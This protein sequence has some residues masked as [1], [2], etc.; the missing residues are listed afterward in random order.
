MKIAIVIHRYGLDIN[1]GSELHCRWIAE[2]LAKT[3]QVDILTTCAKDYITWRNELPEG[4]QELNS[5][6]IHRF[7]VERERNIYEFALQSKRVFRNPKMN[8]EKAELAWLKSEGPYAPKLI[9]YITR[10]QHNYD[11]FIFYCYRY[12]LSY[13]GILTVPK[14]SILIPTAEHD[15]TI[16]LK[17]S[18]TLLNKPKAIIYLTPEEKQLIE[19]ITHN[20]SI[21]N[22]ILGVGITPP[23]TLQIEDFKKKYQLNDDFLL[24]VGRIDPNKGCDQLFQYYLHYLKTHRESRQIP[25]LVLLGKNVMKIPKHQQIVYLGTL[26]EQDKW[27][28]LATAKLFIMPSK[29]ESLCIA[30]LEAMSVGK[31]VLV[32]GTC[33]VLKGHCRRSNG[34]LYYQSYEEFVATLDYLL[35]HD[36][37]RRQLGVQGKEYIDKNYSW[38][39]VEFAYREFIEKHI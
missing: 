26:N 28:A 6:T 20:E 31:A 22:A 38:E 32:N 21:P 30:L 8:S 36:A 11:I 3:N 2:R 35:H 16:Y 25:K 13:H 33:D 12:Y 17:I 14:K 9:E 19:S 29:Y 27:N 18:K 4:T 10:Y 1:G 5:V 23:A 24:Y 37:E 34:G 39:T 7:K 15:Q